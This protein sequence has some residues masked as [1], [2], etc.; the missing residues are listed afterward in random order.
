MRYWSKGS[1]SPPRMIRP[2]HPGPAGSRRSPRRTSAMPGQSTDTTTT[3]VSAPTDR[4][5]SPASIPARGPPPG[6][7]SRVRPTPTGTRTVGGTTATTPAPATSPRAAHTRSI[8]RTPPSTRS[9][10]ETPPRRSPP[11]PPTTIAAS[12]ARGTP[13]PYDKAAPTP[14]TPTARR[15]ARPYAASPHPP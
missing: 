1:G 9:G 14:L 5:A 7:S 4:A 15:S 11:P 10:L 2:S 13:V 3:H 8:R 12:C 6:G